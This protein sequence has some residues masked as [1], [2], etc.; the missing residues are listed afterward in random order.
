MNQVTTAHHQVVVQ[1][2]FR[3]ELLERILRVAR[4]R[5]FHVCAMNMVHTEM[6]TVNIELTV[7]SQKSISQL[8]L[9]LKKLFDVSHVE[10]HQPG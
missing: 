1:A 3:P 4:H 8:L 2:R 7:K 6:D 9:Q 10:V 5:G